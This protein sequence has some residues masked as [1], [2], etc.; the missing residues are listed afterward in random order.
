MNI[1]ALF[2]EAVKDGADGIGYSA[3]KQPHKTCQGKSFDSGGCGNYYAPAHTYI[4][5]HR[6]NGIFFKVDCSENGCH[7]GKAPHYREKQPAPTGRYGT[8]GA[9]KE[10]SICTA[11]KKI[12]SAVV[13]HLKDL[14]CRLMSEGV[15]NA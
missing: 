8:D 4:A 2:T 3:R 12:Y 13:E 15:V 6:E 10:G 14:F 9:E 7:S 11:D 5:Y 1:A